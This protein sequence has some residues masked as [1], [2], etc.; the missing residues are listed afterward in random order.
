MDFVKAVKVKYEYLSTPEVELYINRA[1]SI[2]VEQL[3]PTDISVS[4]DT[5]IVPSRFDMWILDCI[6]ELIERDGISS[7]TA[8]KENGGLLCKV[9]PC[10]LGRFFVQL[11]VRVVF[12]PLQL[13]RHKRSKLLHR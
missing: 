1:K 8:Y 6:D 13:G 11:I 9:R 12:Q 3:Y 5:Y 4:Y 10:Y 7:L 2:L